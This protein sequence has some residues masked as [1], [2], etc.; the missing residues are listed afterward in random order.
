V[1][2]PSSQ[3]GGGDDVKALRQELL[4]LKIT[5]RGKGH[6]IE[7]RQKEGKISR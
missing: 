1:V 5:N 3:E 2:A 4:D 6:F 7:Q